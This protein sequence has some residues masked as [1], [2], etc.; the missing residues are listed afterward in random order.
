ME[1]FI[2][3][4]TFAAECHPGIIF[5]I[6]PVLEYFEHNLEYIPDRNIPRFQR[7]QVFSS[8]VLL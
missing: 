6:I 7:R 3:A 2:P 5:Q 8:T 4:A 1:Y